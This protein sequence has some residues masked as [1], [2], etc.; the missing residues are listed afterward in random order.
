MNK[1]FFIILV[2]VIFFSCSCADKKK[3]VNAKLIQIEYNN[4]YDEGVS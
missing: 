3:Y 4:G 1:Y 2:N